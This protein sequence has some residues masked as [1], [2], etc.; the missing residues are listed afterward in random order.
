MGSISF[1]TVFHYKRDNLEP[2]ERIADWVKD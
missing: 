2:S 1:D